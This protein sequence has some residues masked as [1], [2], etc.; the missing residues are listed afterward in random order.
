MRY[1]MKQRLFAWGEDF[2]VKDED[3]KDAFFVDGRAFSVADKLSFQDLQGNELAFISEELYSLGPTYRIFRNGTQYATVKKS[4]LPFGSTHFSVNVPNVGKL[5][6]EGDFAGH[7]YRIRR[8]GQAIAT[9]S[10]QWFTE[11]ATYGVEIGDGEDVVLLLATSVVID[12]CYNP[13][14]HGS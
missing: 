5:D 4:M 11:P 3:G 8:D 9:I 13:S 12:M 6:V 7:A 14:S 1:L 10:R 2:V